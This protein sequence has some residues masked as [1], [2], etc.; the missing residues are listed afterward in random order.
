MDRIIYSVYTGHRSC[1]TKRKQFNISHIIIG[2]N[3]YFSFADEGL[4]AADEMA[5][6]LELQKKM[7]KNRLTLKNRGQKGI[8]HNY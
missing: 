8:G 7:G 1:C 2:D 5:A 3:R 6:I 4:I